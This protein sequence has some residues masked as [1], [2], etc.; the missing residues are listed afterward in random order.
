MTTPHETHLGSNAETYA[1]DFYAWC[2]RTAVLVREGHWDA[3]DQEALIEELES[4]GKSQKRELENRLHVLVMHLLKW[5]AQPQ[6]RLTSPSWAST[7]R[8]QRRQIALLLRDSP[9]LRRDVPTLLAHLY[10]G[11]RDDAALEMGELGPL[12]PAQT[13]PT[14]RI[15]GLSGRQG[16]DI[17]WR[18]TLPRT[19]PWTVA[20]VLDKD[21]WP[22]ELSDSP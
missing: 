2:L 20:Q 16:P 13:S 19:C 8:E 12:Q 4:L 17:L 10:P 9:S 18:S 22:S 7:I 15:V 21:F 14:M 6:L 3:I 11:A 5:Q 1:Q